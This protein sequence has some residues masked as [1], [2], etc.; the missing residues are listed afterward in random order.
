MVHRAVLEEKTSYS[1]VVSGRGVQVSGGNID[2]GTTRPL[3][4]GEGNV[5]HKLLDHTETADWRMRLFN[6]KWLNINKG[7]SYRKILRCINKDQIRNL[8]V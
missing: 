6:G 8:N 1:S 3:R 5:R 4:V 2:K 7:K